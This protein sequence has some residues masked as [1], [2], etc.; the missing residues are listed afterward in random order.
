MNFGQS[1]ANVFARERQFTEGRIQQVRD[2]NFRAK[3]LEV[4]DKLVKAQE[5]LSESRVNALNQETREK[6]EA[7]SARDKDFYQTEADNILRQQASSIEAND[8]STS[9]SKAREAMLN[10]QGGLTQAQTEL[11]NNQTKELQQKISFVEKQLAAGGNPFASGGGSDTLSDDI[12]R[13]TE[14]IPEYQEL[15]NNA[16]RITESTDRSISDAMKASAKQEMQ[17]YS[18][19]IRRYT[20][21]QGQIIRRQYPDYGSAQVDS[22][23]PNKKIDLSDITNDSN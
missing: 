21:L 2:L 18:D 11:V 23:Q 20:I 4:Q 6:E 7:N 17:E 8:A 15:Y 1:I 19:V 14:S 10:K 22:L 9:F 16:K 13:I 5:S 12:L 3:Q